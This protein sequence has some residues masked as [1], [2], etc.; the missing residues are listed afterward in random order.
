MDYISLTKCVA[1]AVIIT[2]GVAGLAGAA[3]AEFV[4][5]IAAVVFKVDKFRPEV[6]SIIAGVSSGF[7]CGYILWSQG[8]PLVLSIVATLIAIY[9][10]QPVHDIISTI[11]KFRTEEVLEEDWLQPK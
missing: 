5:Q 8:S 4:K 6:A 2:A 7:L 1:E 3:T 10:P 11:K 9:A